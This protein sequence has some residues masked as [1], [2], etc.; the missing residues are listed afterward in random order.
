MWVINVNWF[1]CLILVDVCLVSFPPAPLHPV[2][3]TAREQFLKVGKVKAIATESDNQMV[4][5]IVEANGLNK[6]KALE[7]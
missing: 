7:M 6:I 2:A 3:T 4:T 1:H 5:Y